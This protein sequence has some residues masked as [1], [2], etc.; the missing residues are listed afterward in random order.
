MGFEV[1][2]EHK[3]DSVVYIKG[4]KIYSGIQS[5]LNRNYALILLQAIVS[6]LG[7]TLEGGTIIFDSAINSENLVN[8]IKELKIERVIV[9]PALPS[10]AKFLS[11]LAQSHI[12]V[13]T[14]Q[15]RY[16]RY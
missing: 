7:N 10:D 15:A 13:V 2:R 5:A 9:P 6:D 4:N 14:T 11:E 3:S 1:A 12:D 8:K 16:H